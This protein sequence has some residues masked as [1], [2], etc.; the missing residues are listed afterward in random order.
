MCLQRLGIL[1]KKPDLRYKKLE[2]AREAELLATQSAIL[3]TAA[4]LLKAGGRLVYSTC[5]IDRQK[6]S[7]RSR[8]FWPATRS[9]RWWSLPQ[10]C[11]P[12]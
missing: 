12:G 3:D 10:R 9:L 4:Q 11:P 7:S 6:T 1:A 5:T 8:H 2:P